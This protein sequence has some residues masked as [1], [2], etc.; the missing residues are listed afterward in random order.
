MSDLKSA[1]LWKLIMEVTEDAYACLEDLPEEEKWGLASK[2]RG[3]AGD[4]ATHAAEA[5]GAV[6]PRDIKWSLGKARANLFAVEGIYEVAF[7]TGQ[8][9]TSSESILKIRTAIKEVD[10]LLDKASGNIPKWLKEMGA[11]VEREST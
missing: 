11:P 8:L 10:S 5:L 3:R 1:Q 4:A 2:L 7:K 6:D 9:T